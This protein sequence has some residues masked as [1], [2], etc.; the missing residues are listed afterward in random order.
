M[1]RFGLWDDMLAESPP[2]T[3]LNALAVAYRYGRVM[4][5]AAKGRSVEA[6]GELATH[7]CA[8]GRAAEAENVYREDLRRHPE[9]G[10]AL[11]GL[12]QS[13][14]AQHK[15]ADAHAVKPAV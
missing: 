3:R 10:W 11:Y 12:A 14:L 15:D 6:K 8:S 4:A 13:L 1:V 2:D 7:S 5:L 9:N